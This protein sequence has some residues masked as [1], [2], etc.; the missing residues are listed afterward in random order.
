MIKKFAR[1]REQSSEQVKE[2]KKCGNVGIIYETD[3]FLSPTL[4]R[5]IWYLPL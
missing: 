3:L 1:G 4:G 5:K 2:T